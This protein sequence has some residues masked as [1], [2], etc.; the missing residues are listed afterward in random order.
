[1]ESEF[2][3]EARAIYKVKLT[4]CDGYRLIKFV[5]KDHIVYDYFTSPDHLF[6]RKEFVESVMTKEEFKTDNEQTNFHYFGD[7]EL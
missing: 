5:G 3:F 6:L 1:M 2:K 7:L 4:N